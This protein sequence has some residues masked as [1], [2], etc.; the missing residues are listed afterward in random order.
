MSANEAGG[1]QQQQ[2]S[3]NARERGFFITIDMLQVTR[4]FANREI[5]RRFEREQGVSGTVLLVFRH[6]AVVADV[7]AGFLL[8]DL[9]LGLGEG[10]GEGGETTAEAGYA[11]GRTADGRV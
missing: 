1:Q 5:G 6:V 11:G 7:E 2:H 10:G 4:I 3:T 8:R 9:E